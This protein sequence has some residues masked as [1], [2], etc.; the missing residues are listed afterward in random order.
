LNQRQSARRLHKQLKRERERASGKRD[1]A[2]NTI[3]NNYNNSVHPIDVDVAID[4]D[5]T[6][7]RTAGSN[8]SSRS[9]NL[10]ANRG[11]ARLKN[12]NDYKPS[13]HSG[14]R[15]GKRKRPARTTIDI[16]DN[17]SSRNRGIKKDDPDVSIQK[18]KLS[19]E[20][21]AIRQIQEIFPQMDPAHIVSKLATGPITAQS[22]QILIEKFVSEPSYP[23][24]E[25]IRKTKKVEKPKEVDYA[26]DEYERTVTY[27][28]Q[29]NDQLLNKFPFMSKD[30]ISKLLVHY[31]GRYFKC[32][33]H[34]VDIMKQLKDGPNISDVDRY[35]EYLR[36]ACGGRL[37]EE[38]RNKF[39]ITN[40]GI[41]Y[42]SMTLKHP[43]KH[44]GKCNEVSDTV[45]KDE[46]HFTKKKIREWTHSIHKERRRMAARKEA[47]ENGHTIECTCCYGDYAMEEMVSCQEGHL[48][49]MDCL[50]RYAQERVFGNSDLGKKGCIELCCMDM[51]GCENFFSRDQLEKSLDEK[52]MKK[53]DELQTTLVLEQA[54][55]DGLCKCPQCD[56][57]A[58]LP[59]SEMVFQCPSCEFESCRKCREESH[60][61]L[62]C[63]E[64]ERKTETSAR[65][66]V[67]E[68]MTKARIRYCP[69]KCKQGFYKVSIVNT[70]RIGSSKG[71]VCH[72]MHLFKSWFASKNTHLH[73][74]L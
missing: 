69:K 27:K 57:Q 56:F 74:S 35:D 42:T 32:H 1:Q 51:S 55:M 43:K 8:H 53:Y 17:E 34:I 18:V 2:A 60:I 59:E 70:L 13:V 29:C 47:E 71:P 22:I 49:C 26:N 3:V 72:N 15:V 12:D 45:L 30:G 31:N 7:Q 9:D 36:L 73:L 48:F 52:V 40:N 20:Q 24:I 25:V 58:S 37:K 16:D 23:K 41:K 64:V 38:D 50:K 68:A 33:F 28:Y 4:V 6:A 10:L 11:V 61:P 19:P 62:R 63:E 54:G 39:A 66:Q 44:R 65:L 46:I 21:A 67:E 14:Y 5:L